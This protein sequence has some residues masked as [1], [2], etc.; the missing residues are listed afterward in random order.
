MS[1]DWFTLIVQIINLI[2]LLFLLRR[3]L[4]L[5]LLK[6]VEIRQKIIADELKNAENSRLKAEKAEKM[7][8][9]KAQQ[10][11]QERQQVLADVQIE[12]EKI[13]IALRQQAEDQYHKELRQWQQH[14]QNDQKSFDIAVQKLTAEHFNRFAEKAFKQ[15]AN[16]DL[17]DWIIDRFMQKIKDM[18]AMEKDK[19]CIKF[20]QDYIVYIQSAG[21]LS[22]ERIKTLKAFLHKELN[23]SANTRFEHRVNEELVSGISVQMGDFAIEWSLSGYLEEFKQTMTSEITRLINRGAL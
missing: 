21:K 6:A 23:I 11:E 7:C 22:D 9:Q 2:V 18:S 16:A 19:L 5:P 8:L 14:L 4:Y 15:M 1:I 10:I 17:N 20:Q 12:A 3:F 13:A